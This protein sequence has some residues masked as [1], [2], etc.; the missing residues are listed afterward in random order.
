MKSGMRLVSAAICAA[1][2]T[3]YLVAS[4]IA[5]AQTE[6]A[7]P[8]VPGSVPEPQAAQALDAMG[9]YLR[10][11]KQFQLRTNGTIERVYPDGQKLQ[12]RR[13]VTY[14]VSAPDQMMVDVQTDNTHRRIYYNGRLMT[15]SAVKIGKYVS[16]PVSGSIAEVTA[17]AYDRFGIDFPLQ[18]LFRWGSPSAVTV[19]PQSGYVVGDT[20]VNGQPATQ[21][22]FRQP[23]VDF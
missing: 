16:F 13:D 1:L 4:Y 2:C 19:P 6:A 3:Q 18:D 14:T 21:Y 12:F 10:T 9:T 7:G 17:N 20:E 5:S 23:G 22:A 11:L 15:V 8:Q